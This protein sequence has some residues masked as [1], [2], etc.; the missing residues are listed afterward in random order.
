MNVAMFLFSFMESR[1]PHEGNCEP[2]SVVSEGTE[3]IYEDGRL[4]LKTL[5]AL[6]MGH[7]GRA[8]HQKYP[9]VCVA[10]D[11]P[12]MHASTHLPSSRSCMHT[13]TSLLVCPTS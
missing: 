7:L 10:F 9:P 13:F 11:R 6:R 4:R 8:F 2:L 5:E 3:D 12:C 1:R